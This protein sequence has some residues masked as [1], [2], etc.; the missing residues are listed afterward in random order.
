MNWVKKGLIY[1]P[2][3]EISL[4]KDRAIAPVCELLQNDILR[5]Y[6]SSR[7]L[8]GKSTPI[9]LD[10]N[11]ER[12]EQI[13]FVNGN[14]ILEF[15]RLGSFDDNGILSSSIVNF[16]N[17]KYLYYVGWNPKVTV[18]YHLSIGLAI[19]ENGEPFKKIS[20]GPLLDRSLQEP[21]FNTAP[22]VMK[23]VD[24]WKMWYVS[25][26]GWKVVNNNPEPLYNIKYATSRDGINWLRDGTVAIGNDEFAEAVGKPFVYTEDGLYRMIYSYRNSVNYRTDPQNS[27]RLGYAESSDGKKWKRMDEKMGIE[28]SEQGWDSI[29][30]E[31]ASSYMYNDKRYLIYN[32]NGFGE[33]GFGYAVLES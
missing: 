30:M 24:D 33:S 1:K 7:D 32:G 8:S 4:V 16:N 9:F 11:P 15:G 17:K 31:Y 14:P 28:F 27:Y 29:M 23:D 12:P 6:F 3:Q 25:C 19:S 18:A 2:D 20:D 22:F 21:F 26:T 13:I 10:T 5:I